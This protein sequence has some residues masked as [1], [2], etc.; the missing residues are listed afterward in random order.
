MPTSTALSQNYP[1]PFRAATVIR[2]SVEQPSN[3]VVRV[4]D[5]TGKEIATLV[6]EKKTIGTFSIGYTA[7]HGAA[8]TYVCRL[9]AQSE[10]G[11]TTRKSRNMIVK[12]S[13]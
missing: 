11:T 5:L 13:Q 3:V 4:Y 10:D 8:G 7:S 1:N 12:K 2:Y 6:N 9:I